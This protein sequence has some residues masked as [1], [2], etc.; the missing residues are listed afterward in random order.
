MNPELN[1]VDHFETIF[2]THFPK[3]KFFIFTLLKSEAD[4]EDLTQDVFIKLWTNYE[5]WQD[6]G[7]KDGYIYLLA[8][9]MTF[10]FIRHK[11]FEDDYLNKQMRDS[12]IKEL[13]VEDTLESIYC[14]EIRLILELTIERFPQRRKKIFQMS[15]L[16]NRN[17]Q[18]IAVSLDISVRTVE[19][20]IY[21]A[22]QELKKIV[23]ILFFLF[24]L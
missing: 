10:D 20:Q 18:E 13:S 14:D 1:P 4:A 6:N 8:K 22:I 17:N 15:R 12:L 23:F 3:V 11:K 16:E 24:F 5:T 7:G 21:L 2:K 9:N 19:H